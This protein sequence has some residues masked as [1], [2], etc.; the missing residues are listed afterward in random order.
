MTIFLCEGN[1]FF[2]AY[3]ESDLVGK[4]VFI[5]LLFLSVVSWSVLIQ[6][7]WLTRR[8]KN[9]SQLFRKVF[10]HN[11]AKPLDITPPL[12]QEYPNAFAIIYDVVKTKT[13]EIFEKNKKCEENS[14]KTLQPADIALLETHAGATISSLTNFAP[15]K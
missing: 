6:K 5:L 8:V 13:L 11:S 10:I 3:T 14:C 1:P 2:N 4:V 15:A 12:A 7:I 9:D